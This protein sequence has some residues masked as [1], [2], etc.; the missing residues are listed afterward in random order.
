VKWDLADLVSPADIAA[1]CGVG[2][3]AVSNWIVRY[4]DFP[5]ALTTVAQGKTDLYSR[6]AVIAWYDLK[7]WKNDGP[8]SKA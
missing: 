7:D 8:W 6:K 5:R 4:P 3:P 2:K 1:E